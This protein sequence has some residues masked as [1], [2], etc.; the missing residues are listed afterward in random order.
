MKL[1]KYFA[2]IFLLVMFSISSVVH[3]A[4]I[5]HVQ[6]SDDA[7]SVYGPWDVYYKT[8]FILYD[9]SLGRYIAEVVDIYF[10]NPAY[11]RIASPDILLTQTAQQVVEADSVRVKDAY[12]P[13]AD[14]L[15]LYAVHP[16]DV[17]NF[18]STLIPSKT[19]NLIY[20]VQFEDGWHA[21]FPAGNLDRGFDYIQPVAQ[22]LS[23]GVSVTTAVLERYSPPTL[24]MNFVFTTD[25]SPVWDALLQVDD[26]D[27][28]PVDDFDMSLPLRMVAG[29][30]PAND[31]DNDGV[32]DSD[33][34][35]P[36]NY[37]PGQSN[38]DGD[39]AGDACDLCPLDA[40]N[41]ADGDGVCGDID[42]CPAVANAD[43]V[44]TDSDG[45][46]DA[47]NTGIDND[48]D[49]WSNTLDNCPADANPDQANA[50]GDVLG[51]ICDACPTDPDNDADGD[52]FCA[53]VDNCPLANNPDQTDTNNDGEGNACD[54]DDDGDGIAD[55][56]DNCP[57]VPNAGQADDDQDGEGNACDLDDDNDNVVDAI[58][59]CPGTAIGA[60][61]NSDGCSIAQHCPTENSWKNHG[62]YVR[63][64]AK[65]AESFVADGLI[66]EEDKDAEISE[67]GSSEVGKK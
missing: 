56:S 13:S 46:G 44:D 55:A 26:Y 12:G 30:V 35:C 67:A 4:Q 58:D 1:S 24:R 38:S 5:W 49:D 31:S 42:N 16:F 34:N 2:T 64:V 32:P 27:N 39:I 8:E 37:N 7:S 66:S 50:D 3:A 20:F 63:C 65:T 36:A 53:G 45:F 21:Q 6:M 60:V 22:G 59:Q 61:A 19:T 54:S 18:T 47:C 28:A 43:Q 62:A 33:D 25:N 48:G 40:D 15:D 23:T 10:D 41:D 14:T 11:G 17:G 52:G 51:D 29:S 9:D 57:L